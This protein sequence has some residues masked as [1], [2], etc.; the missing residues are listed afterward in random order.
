MH[1][2]NKGFFSAWYPVLLSS[3]NTV[4]VLVSDSISKLSQLISIQITV[5][6]NLNQT[7][8]P[9]SLYAWHFDFNHSCLWT[10][11]PVDYKDYFQ[12]FEYEPF[13]RNILKYFCKNVKKV[14]RGMN[15]QKEFP[16]TWQRNLV[17]FSICITFTLSFASL[18][19]IPANYFFIMVY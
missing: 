16:D 6:P 13:S 19:Y 3:F 14:R 7:Q 1:L 12:T 9:L 10:S 11:K 5:A 4:I 17:K 2:Q 8:I 15:L 18:I